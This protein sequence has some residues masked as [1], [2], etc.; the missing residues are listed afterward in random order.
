L[1]GDE[2]A[3][4]EED[5]E[6]GG[7]EDFELIQDLVRCCVK[8]GDGDILQVVLHYIKHGRYQQLPHL[9]WTAHDFMPES[10]PGVA[11]SELCLCD[12][13][14]GNEELDTF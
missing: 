10:A 2:A 1:F 11:P 4:Q 13:R 3:M 12:E 7:G 5:G 9:L 8:V 6:E 14:G